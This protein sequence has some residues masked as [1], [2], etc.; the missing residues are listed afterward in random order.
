MA[1]ERYT[2]SD[3]AS[4]LAL[5]QRDLTASDI[6]A[7]IGADPYRTPL[8]IFSEK[9]GLI[10][11]EAETPIMRRG[12]WFELAALAALREQKPTWRI[13][14][15]NIYL[16]DAECRLGATPDAIAE[17]EEAPGELINCQIKT[18]AKPAFEREWADAAPMG[19]V[20]QTLAEG[21]L[22][23]AARSILAALVVDTY[24]AEL[25]IHDVP[26]HEAAE[27]RIR[28]IARDFWQAIA[29][30]RR[31]AAD[32]KRDAETI[33]ELFAKPEPGPPLDLSTDNRMP[34]LL[35]EREE[36]REEIER[37]RER[38]EVVEAEIKDKLGAAEAAT[39]PG[40]KVTWKQQTRK[41][42]I[43]PAK[44]FR[45]LRVSQTKEEDAA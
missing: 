28:D 8:R 41:E 17:D 26:R 24:S 13:E 38:L 1:I 42:Y 30:G 11:A 15:P 22:L 32:Y 2:I 29:E 14:Q 6:G 10:L 16:R 45:V 43:V 25:H 19:Y 39:L 23:G 37:D 20:L 33:G 35:Q 44:T 12:R 27:A 40:W 31:P 9:S 4:W 5:R 7:V 34:S 21:Y 3:R 36:L 18:I